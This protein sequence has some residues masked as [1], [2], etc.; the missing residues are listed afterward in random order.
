MARLFGF[1]LDRGRGHLASQFEA[2]SAEADRAG[3][4]WSDLVQDGYRVRG[5]LY[6]GGVLIKYDWRWRINELQRRLEES[7]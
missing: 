1:D 6:A 2:L 5:D 4:R 7:A 3:V